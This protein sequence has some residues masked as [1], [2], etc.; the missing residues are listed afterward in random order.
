[1]HSIVSLYVQD[2]ATR[3]VFAHTY[4]SL[5]GQANS[6]EEIKTR[7]STN[8]SDDS[9][10]SSFQPS[11]LPMPGEDL[12]TTTGPRSV[13]EWGACM[14]M[15]AQTIS[16]LTQAQATDS[17]GPSKDIVLQ[18]RALVA[19]AAAEVA[20]AGGAAEAAAIMA[21]TLGPDGRLRLPYQHQQHQLLQPQQLP[22]SRSSFPPPPPPQ[23]HSQPFQPPSPSHLAVITGVPHPPPQPWGGSGAQAGWLPAGR[24]TAHNPSPP[25][26]APAFAW[27]HDQSPVQAALAAAVGAARPF[28]PL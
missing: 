6:N 12:E 5:P 25:A 1:M 24:M 11:N 8:S 13:Q 23:P 14:P 4:T 10:A 20:A 21:A 18:A 9:P 7:S 17:A 22:P 16:P 2:L 15:V 27:R 28:R 3:Q 26:P 19:A